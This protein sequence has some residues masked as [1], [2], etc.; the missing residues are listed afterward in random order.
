M[1]N[2][3]YLGKMDNNNEIEDFFEE[4]F[5]PLFWYCAMDI[6]TIKSCENELVENY[7]T[8]HATGK[9]KMAKE[10]CLSNLVECKK[11]IGELYPPGIKQMYDE[12]IQYLDDKINENEY[13][14]MD[15]IEMAWCFKEGMEYLLRL[16]RE[17]LRSI[18]MEESETFEMLMDKLLGPYAD[19]GE[20]FKYVG[21][22]QDFG[23]DFENYSE[24]YAQCVDDD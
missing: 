14:V 24:L 17:I 18:K 21:Y 19:I 23:G 10:K 4:K 20:A 12:F 2:K 13:L 5:I 9:I 3:A 1:A 6:E 8:E 16:I 22:D 11:F 15:L 7:G